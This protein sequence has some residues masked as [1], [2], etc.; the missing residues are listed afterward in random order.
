MADN[1]IRRLPV[2]KNGHLIGIVTLVMC[3]VQRSLMRRL[4]FFVA[5]LSGIPTSSRMLTQNAAKEEE[6]R[7][8]GVAG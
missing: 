4:P 8:W 7:S 5:G 6:R 2:M 1:Q 3:E